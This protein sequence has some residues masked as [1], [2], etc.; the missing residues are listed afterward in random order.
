MRLRI[1]LILLVSIQA[2]LSQVDTVW[3]RRY[4]GF[5]DYNDIPC[6][7]AV[8]NGGNVYVTG[9]SYVWDPPILGDGDYLT[10]KY[11]HAGDSTWVKHYDGLWHADDCP[12]GMIVDS[13]NNVYVCGYSMGMD[14]TYDYVTIK[15]NSSGDTVWARSLNGPW[16]DHDYP[17]SFTVDD[18]GNVYVTGHT[19]CAWTSQNYMTIKYSSVGDSVWMRLYNHTANE[20]ESA[21]DIAVDNDGNVYVTGKSWDHATRYDYATVKY[22]S[23]G[24]EVW[25]T[26]Y[27]GVSDSTD[28]AEAITVDTSGNVYVTG[29]SFVSDSAPD[30]V[31]IKYS[32]DGDT[33]WTRYYDGSGGRGDYP[34]AMAIDG[35]GNIY[36][37]GRSVEANADYCVIKYDS[38]GNELWDAHYNGIGNSSDVA[39]ALAIDES[40][41]V[42]VTGESNGSGTFS[43]FATVKYDRYGNEVWTIRY[44]GPASGHDRAYSIAVDSSGYVYVTGESFGGSGTYADYVTIKYSQDTG[45]EEELRTTCASA[46]IIKNTIFRNTLRVEYSLFSPGRVLIQIYDIQGR[47]IRTLVNES[48]HNGNHKLQWSG[49]DDCGRMSSDGVYLIRLATSFGTVTKKVVKVQ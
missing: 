8:D 4:N 11:D 34:T 39:H 40:C 14:A 12:I 36:V 48:R 28:I 24:N 35:A 16:G 6:A 21:N 19:T 44:D 5:T 17:S 20:D 25:V 29:S 37:I 46:L 30:I 41:N 26:R 31:T 33:V 1:Q 2:S 3:T 22:D 42:Y 43:D 45:I 13:H 27:N 47:L 15:Y 9:A 10:I 18:S 38:D 23:S 49:E 7:I 32:G